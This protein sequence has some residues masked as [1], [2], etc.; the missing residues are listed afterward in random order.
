VCEE[1][2]TALLAAIEATRQ[3][4]RATVKREALRQLSQYVGKRRVPLDYP[5]FLARGLDLGS[6]PTE[7]YWKVPRARGS[8][9]FGV[10]HVFLANGKSGG[11][12]SRS[13][14]RPR[15]AGRQAAE[16]RAV[17]GNRAGP[18]LEARQHVPVTV[19]WTRE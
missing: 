15:T 9:R 14:S 4:T 13:V 18:R 16:L 3:R 6:G 17:G 7:S 5:A 19:E 8:G 10:E 11:I 2:G 12:M 1:G